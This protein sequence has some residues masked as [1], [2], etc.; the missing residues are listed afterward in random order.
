[1]LCK[2]AAYLSDRVSV[3]FVVYSHQ[4]TMA[5]LVQFRMKFVDWSAS[6]I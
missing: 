3:R 6:N 4:P 5:S 1:M 2:T